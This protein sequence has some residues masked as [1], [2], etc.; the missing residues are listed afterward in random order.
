MEDASPEGNASLQSTY[1]CV[2]IC[3]Q[4]EAAHCSI[5][6]SQDDREEHSGGTKLG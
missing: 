2:S 4:G 6:I 1:P 5:P 3:D